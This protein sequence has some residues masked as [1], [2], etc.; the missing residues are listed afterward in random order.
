M[1][2]W[3]K[4][5]TSGADVS[6][7][8]L[9]V[10]NGI[11]GSL[12]GTATSASY[13]LTASYAANGGG[14]SVD[15]G[16]LVTTSSFNSYTG[17]IASQFAGTAS[18]ATSASWAPTQNINTGSLV[19]TSSFNSFTSSYN[20]GSFTGSFTGSL[21]GTSSFALSAS[22]ASSSTSA[23]YALTASSAPSY[24][25]LVGGTLLGDLSINT[26][27]NRTFTMTAGGAGGTEIRLLPNTTYGYARINIGNTAQPLDFQM[28]STNV[29]RITQAGNI[30][31]GTLTPNANLDVSGSAIITG[32]LNVIGGITGSLFGTASFAT[33]ASYVQNAQSASYVLQAVSSSY[34]TTASFALN[35]GGGGVS[36]GLVQAFSQGFQN[37]F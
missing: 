1:P 34:A 32:S 16:S 15:T 30:G 11:T 29:M 14:G 31:I 9:T 25:P 4:I 24:L 20:T 8:S 17:S 12:L 10:T 26:S 19:T 23:S 33:T 36:K 3:K 22:Y 6:L 37:I 28:N 13:A 5:I 18:F 7:N 21:Q 2:S 35:A 27:G